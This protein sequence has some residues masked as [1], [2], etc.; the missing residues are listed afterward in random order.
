MKE[1]KDIFGKCTAMLLLLGTFMPVDTH[2][3][4]IRD[5]RAR[6]RIIE[7]LMDSKM[8]A[9]A[10]K[11]LTELIPMITP[12]S[13]IK[14]ISAE[15]ALV[16]CR[17]ET[18]SPDMDAIMDEFLIRY[19]N[20]AEKE[21][22][23]LNY[24]SHYF[25]IKD[26]AKAGSVLR[27]I[28]PE[29]L[30]SSRR[31]EYNFKSS[32]CSM[33]AGNNEKALEG[34]EKVSRSRY[35]MYTVPSLYYSAYI[36]YMNGRYA[37]SIPLFERVTSNPTYSTISRYYLLE[38]HFILKDYD[39]VILNGRNL[40]EDADSE[41]K[42]KT[43]RILSEAYFK[44]GMPREAKMFFEI[45]STSGINLSR[46][47]KYYSAVVSY[48]LQS[49]MS[50]LESFKQTAGNT[51]TIGQSSYM[52][53][54]NCYIKLKNKVA[55]ME[56]YRKASLLDYDMMVKETSMYNYAKL[57]FD[58]NADIRPFN[59]YIRSYPKSKNH[60]E[61][62]GY[63]ASSY[64]ST[65]D[66]AAAADA[67]EKIKEKTIEVTAKMQKA[68]FFRGIELM[69]SGSYRL[70]EEMFRQSVENNAGNTQLNN[71]SKFWLAEA[72]FRNGKYEEAIRTNTELIGNV[73]F[74]RT[75]EAPE[76]LYN[77][78]YCHLMNGGFSESERWFKE[79]L[80][81][82]PTRRR[83]TT[84][85][86]IRLA[87]AYFMQKKYSYAAELYE[88]ASKFTEKDNAYPIYQGAMA[89]GLISNDNKKI[90]MLGDIMYNYQDNPLHSQSVFELGRTLLQ[91]KDYKG[92][93]DCFG[94]LI[95]GKDSLY[96]PKAMVEMGLTYFNMKKNDMAI[97][98]YRRVIEEYPSSPEA[99]NA[100]AGMETVYQSE[101]RITEYFS[102]LDT[103]GLSA[104][105][106]DAE[107]EDMLFNAAEQTFVNRKYRKAAEDLKRFLET[108]PESG[109]KDQALFYIAESLRFSGEQEN[110]SDY[111]RQTM[112]SKDRSIRETSTIT[113][114]ELSYG[115]NKYE[116]ALS[117]YG[118]ILEM[119]SLP[120]NR[121]KAALGEIRSLYRL[122]HYSETSGRIDDFMES[123]LY[124][125]G[126]E[127]ELTYLK[128]KAM[129]FEGKREEAKNLFRRLAEDCTSAE[130][131][132]SRYLLI[133]DA[134]E[135]GKF[136]NVEN[137]TFE[138][139]ETG[140]PHRYWLAKS[141]IILGDSYAERG[142]WTQA[143]AT[144]ESI[145]EGY[146]P[147]SGSDDIPEQI[148]IRLDVIEKEMKSRGT[149]SIP[150]V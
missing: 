103:H 138:F 116:E 71:L 115:L 44:N 13:G 70:A 102:Y 40:Y 144:L 95:N 17:I 89:Y 16:K 24:A 146:S 68:T 56:A 142:E 48:S 47:D 127:T 26:Y 80:D 113:Y 32:Y 133:L 110:A 15:A 104:T 3:Q 86:K 1:M 19:P 132:E 101:N 31:T 30:P 22:L 131:A 69:D 41:M 134:Y 78:G 120:G 91:H 112:D 123:D 109:R 18:G 97:G 52:H 5:I 64:L 42:L 139:A 114:A 46:K 105:K 67:L 85:A 50:A 135:S 129:T 93:A 60:D 62:Y 39:Y 36:H 66:Y 140:T 118:K 9:S 150:A 82:P 38:A 51:D 2:A 117:A 90:S 147:E 35:S 4:D 23:L 119:E 79:Y 57:A 124:N 128:A 12:E 100:L 84:D 106:S 87:D 45:Y 10:G 49:Y 96:I 125:A 122:R 137:M 28:N 73:D 61:I 81:L 136:E 29:K 53:I 83:S 149:D 6:Y 121:E 99:A 20:A 94:K 98:E 111:Y 88:E 11:E 141:F 145:L 65:K 148:R 55:A 43:A 72:E 8:Y 33:R 130:G 77:L 21:E 34:F 74:K 75:D 27:N 7:E 14:R 107:R 58:L 76:T 37:E 25:R 63:I 59:E 54:G 143:K 92:A 108:Y 126:Y